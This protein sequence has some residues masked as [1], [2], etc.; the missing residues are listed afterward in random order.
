MSMAGML[1]N[2]FQNIYPYNAGNERFN[3]V[4]RLWFVHGGEGSGNAHTCQNNVVKVARNSPEFIWLFRSLEAGRAVRRKPCSEQVIKNMV[5]CLSMV[6][7]S[8]MPVLRTVRLG[9]T[10][11]P[12]KRLSVHNAECQNENSGKCLFGARTAGSWKRKSVVRSCLC[13]NCYARPRNGETKEQSSSVHVC[14]LKFLLL[15]SCSVVHCSVR[16]R[17]MVV[18]TILVLFMNFIRKPY[19]RNVCYVCLFVDILLSQNC[20]KLIRLFSPKRPKFGCWYSRSLSR[21]YRLF[22]I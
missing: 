14:C 17:N 10:F 4:V 7:R 5:V 16:K 21:N 22:C 2:M 3:M 11:R 9:R 6:V 18:H 20:L 8:V 1:G 19:M 13:H 15:L 12:K